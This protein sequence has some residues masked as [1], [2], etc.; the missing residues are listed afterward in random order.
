MTNLLQFTSNVRK[1]H[2]Q[3]NALACDFRTRSA[4]A[5]RLTVGFSTTYLEL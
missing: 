2:R 4:N 5:L 3:F 1:P